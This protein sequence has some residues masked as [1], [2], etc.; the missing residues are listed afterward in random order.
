MDALVRMKS[1]TSFSSK[2]RYAEARR[3]LEWRHQPADLS[4]VL[5]SAA[6]TAALFCY[7]LS[8]FLWIGG[9]VDVID[10]VPV[11]Y[12]H[13]FSYRANYE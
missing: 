12:Y 9:T 13:L 6:V 7:A 11:C 2:E 3:K 5:L 10:S 1:S 4:D 8:S